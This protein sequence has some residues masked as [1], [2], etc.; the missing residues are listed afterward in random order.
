MAITKPKAVYTI[1]IIDDT[2]TLTTG[3]GK[4]YFAIP[5]ELNGFNMTKVAA[6]VSTNSSSGTPT[7][8]IA[9]VTD[10]V[11]ML[12]TLITIDANEATS[13]TAATPPVIDTSKDDVATGDLLRIDCDAAG[14]GAKGAGLVL[15]FSK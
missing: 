12:S 3:D 7:F 10:G 5:Q 1:K 13:Y 8:Q 6:F 11:D 2:T 9:N 4:F 15:T 14:T